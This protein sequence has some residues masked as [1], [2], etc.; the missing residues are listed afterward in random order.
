MIQSESWTVLTDSCTRVQVHHIIL[1]IVHRSSVISKRTWA[2]TFDRHLGDYSTIM[3]LLNYWL[4]SHV[5]YCREVY[6]HK[7]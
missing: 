4:K 7:T 2:I 1:N 3:D 5:Q 6:R